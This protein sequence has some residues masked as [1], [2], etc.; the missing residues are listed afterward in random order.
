MMSYHIPPKTDDEEKIVGGVLTLRQV[1]FIGG[2]VLLGFLTAVSLFFVIGNFSII[3]GILVA[4]SGTPFAFYK[5]NNLTL[6][7]NWRRKKEYEKKNKYLI[8][9]IK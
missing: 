2:G 6:I 4:F 1:A 3:V 9:K 7:G 5:K 8:N